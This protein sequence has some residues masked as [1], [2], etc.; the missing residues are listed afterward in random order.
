[1]RDA[2]IALYE[3]KAA[4]K[5]CLRKFEP[6][7]RNE[8][9]RELEL[10]NRIRRAVQNDEFELFYQPI[11]SATTGEVAGLEALLRW[12][13][14]TALYSPG[15][16]LSYLEQSALIVPVGERVIEQAVADYG[17]WMRDV[18][19]AR[20]LVGSLNLSRV[21]FRSP[22]LVDGLLR[23]LEEHGLPPSRL[24]IE[25]T[26]TAVSDDIVLMSKTLDRLRETGIH[27]AIDDF[28]VGQSSLSS[29]YE[30]PADI[31]KIDGTFVARIDGSGSQPVIEAILNMAHA[32]GLH[33]TAEGVETEAQRA[34]LAEAGC[35]FLQGYLLGRPVPASQVPD[36]FR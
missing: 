11:V 36:L 29:L 14:P 33:T 18:P 15:A 5:H 8:A 2:D 26:E 4:G 3:A 30:L 34:F 13:T 16:F 22:N 12:R 28:G 6:Q 21:Q 25:V 17:R 32:V 19:G 20:K 31:L 24:V 9:D 27:V 7:M 35:D 1:M 23:S 10:Q